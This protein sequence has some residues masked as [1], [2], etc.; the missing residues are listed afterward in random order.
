M[1]TKSWLPLSLVAWI[2][3]WCFWMLTTRRFH[4]NTTIAVVVTTAL[5]AAY[6]TAAY[7]NHLVLLPRLWDAGKRG[8]YLAALVAVM[9]GFTAATLAIIRF[10]YRSWLGPDPDPNGVYK[11][12]AID[13][14]GMVLHLAAAAAVVAFAKKIRGAA[15]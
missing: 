3:V 11:H 5:V 8:R 7:L 14:A 12:F 1:R 4:P 13:F 9:L 2:G 6:A 15:R 10:S